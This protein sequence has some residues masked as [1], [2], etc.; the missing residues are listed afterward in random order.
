[1]N[2]YEIFGLDRTLTVDNGDLQKR[3]YELSRQYHPDR[4][5]SKNP[6]EQQAVLDQ[7]S[8]L[9]DAYRVLRDPVQRAEYVL[10][11]EGFDIGEQRSKDVPP[12]LL[13]EVF[14]L[15]MVLEE[16]RSGDDSARPQLEEAR[17]KFLGMRNQV[18][19]EL[20]GLFAKYDASKDRAALSEIRA[21]LNRRRYIRNLVNEVEKELNVDIPN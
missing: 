3:F 5:R 6:A 13:E 8:L 17:E 12:E 15:N 20:P 2:Y 9:N 7:S 18:D 1:L 19:G 11:Q 16:L 21:V 4:S 14:E 10:K